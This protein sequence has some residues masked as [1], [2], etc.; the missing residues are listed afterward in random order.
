MRLYMQTPPV[1]GERLRY[2]QLVLQPDL[3]GGWSLVREWGHQGASGRMKREHFASY[4][5]AEAALQ[6]VREA[7][8]QRGYRVVFCQGDRCT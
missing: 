6:R 8:Q 4:D 5:E 2:Y 7:Q 1:E 3:L